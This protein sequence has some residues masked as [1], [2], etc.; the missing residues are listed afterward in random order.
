MDGCQLEHNVLRFLI[1][2]FSTSGPTK[3]MP[4]DGVQRQDETSSRARDRLVQV[5]HPR[6]LLLISLRT[7]SLLPVGFPT[8]AIVSECFRRIPG[9]ASVSVFSLFVSRHVKN[10]K[11]TAEIE[12]TEND[13]RRTPPFFPLTCWGKDRYLPGLHLRPY[14]ACGM[15][16][17]RS[18]ICMR[19]LILRFGCCPP[20]GG[21]WDGLRKNFCLA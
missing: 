21:N 14:Q 8:R 19:K 18:L 1:Q 5:R 9:L 2:L 20:K 10:N 15:L 4:R 3:R 6:T 16:V 17:C 13:G 11:C 7:P 12:C